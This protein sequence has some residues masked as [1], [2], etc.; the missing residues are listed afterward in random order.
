MLLL[1][2][3]S[4]VQVYYFV[5]TISTTGAGYKEYLRVERHSVALQRATGYPAL[6]II[7]SIANYSNAR[8]AEIT[9]RPR[10]QVATTGDRLVF[11][12]PYSSLH[13]ALFG[14]LLDPACP[15][16][17]PRLRPGCAAILASWG[18]Y[19]PRARWDLIA[20]FAFIPLCRGPPT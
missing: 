17:L 13:I 9:S 3:A 16:A 5:S 4:A 1:Y 11:L 14:P 6:L 20:L 10:E 8:P 12:H 19:G 15:L 7:E 2:K 18:Y